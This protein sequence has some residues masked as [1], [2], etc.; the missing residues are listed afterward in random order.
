[1]NQDMKH[2]QLIHRF[3]DYCKPFH[4]YHRARKGRWNQRA[5][6][7]NMGNFANSRKKYTEKEEERETDGG[8]MKDRMGKWERE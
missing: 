8:I 4:M 3:C 2:A 6:A 5:L 7:S 1:M